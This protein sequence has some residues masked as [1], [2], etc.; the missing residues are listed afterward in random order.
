M[1]AVCHAQTR[2]ETSDGS[3]ESQR[4]LTFNNLSRD[5]SLVELYIPAPEHASPFD[6][7]LAT[8]NFFAFILGKPLVGR[9]MGQTYVDL[10][11]RM[12]LFRSSRVDN[13][14]DFLEYAENQGYRD[15]VECTD[16]A[17][18]SLCYAERYKLRDVWIDA[19]A[20]CVGMNESLSISPEY[21]VGQTY[22]L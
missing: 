4:I 16:Y 8:R 21:L 11:E 12:E 1:L 18:A 14:R 15:L 17:L 20:H 19:F 5:T 3:S 6:W 22:Q 9:Q 7:H 10:F 13:H 2:I